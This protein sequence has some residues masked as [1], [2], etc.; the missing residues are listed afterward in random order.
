[1]PDFMDRMYMLNYQEKVGWG[2]KR[3]F[4]S[5]CCLFVLH[6]RRNP[7]IRFIF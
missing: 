2:D 3:R 4:S 1:M 5:Y 6:P 7:A